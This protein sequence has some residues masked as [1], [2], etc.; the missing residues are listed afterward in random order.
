MKETLWGGASLGI[1]WPPQ[2]DLLLWVALCLLA[3]GVLG[4][5]AWRLLKVPRAVGYVAAGMLAGVFGLGIDG[6]QLGGASR[7]IT[8]L[9]LALLLFEAG[10][11]LR[12][13]W[14]RDNPWLLA[15]FVLEALV[16]FAAVSAAL[17]AIGVEPPV[18]VVCGAI[19]M[20]TSPAVAMQVASETRSA[21]QVTERMIVFAVLTTCVA[22]LAMEFVAGWK[23]ASWGEGNLL[24]GIGHPLYQLVGCGVLA[25][26]LAA[27]V[28][29]MSRRLDL[30]D[31]HATLLVLGA[32]L[33]ALA[34][35]TMARLSTLL[36]PLLAGIALRNH[37]DR[38]GIWPRQFGTAGRALVLM[39]FVI[40]GTA[41]S[42]EVLRAGALAA[43]V[44]VVV[45]FAAKGGVQLALGL[46]SGTSWRQSAALGL[47]ALPLSSPALVMIADLNGIAPVLGP[48][49][50]AIVFSAVA[51]TELL[52]PLAVHAALRA[53]K[54]TGA[55]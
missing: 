25:A 12:L 44:L 2:P 9:A 43:G 39:L 50:A 23:H 33:L 21:G 20:A 27:G 11:H 30:R 14:L 13:R 55:R 29:V 31:E 36:V 7:R 26:A 10:S 53:S 38:P 22:V 1:A 16:T 46:P 41:W 18:A 51:F 4:E 32:V 54:E 6:A 28:A 3:A 42:F 19:A 49:V 37:T 17:W 47:S 34:L 48:K 35:A 40:A 24:R 45:R 52:G 8:E 15:S 5:L